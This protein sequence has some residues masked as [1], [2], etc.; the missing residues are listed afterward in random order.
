MHSLTQGY[1]ESYTAQGD[2]E[3]IDLLLLISNPIN[4]AR[5]ERSVIVVVLPLWQNQGT[6]EYETQVCAQESLHRAPE[7][8]LIASTTS[9]GLP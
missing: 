6:D 1:H 3:M 9:V 2:L 8:C 7:Y 4:E 5:Q